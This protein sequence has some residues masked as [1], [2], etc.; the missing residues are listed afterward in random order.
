MLAVADYCPAQIGGMPL[1][2]ESCVNELSNEPMEAGDVVVH[3]DPYR[4]GLHT[5]EHTFFTPIFVGGE[6]MGYA[7]A[8]GHVSETG[9][10]VPG[11]F[12]SEATEIFHEG[13]RVPP[14]KIKRRGE[15]VDDVWKLMLANVRTPRQNYGDYRALISSVELGTQRIAD[16]IGKYGKKVFRQA[17]HELLDYSEKRMRAELA[18]IP[19]GRYRFSDFM[20]DDGIDDRPFHIR[21]ECVVQNDE[22]I[23]DFTGSDVQAR[24]AINAT[25]GV[26]RS[27]SYNAILHL[28]D[29]SIPKNSG[30]F[31]PIRIVAP[32]G[33]IVNVDYPAPEVGGNTETH[34]RIAYTVIGA[35]AKAVPDRA[36][37]T[38]AAT[39]CN[40]L[41]GGNDPRSGEY[42]VCYDFLSA[43]WGGRPF[44]DGNNAVNCINGNCRMIPTEVL[45]VRY[46]FLIEEF[47]LV[48]DSGGAGKY[49][50][51]LGVRKKFLCR[52]APITISHMGDRHKHGPWGLYGGGEAAKA[53]LKI[54]RAGSEKWQSAIQDSAKISPSKFAGM[55]LNPGDRIR[56]T[57]AGGGGW[58]K[59]G[60]RD[61]AQ[62]ANDVGEG[63]VS[64]QRAQ[65]DY[66][67]DPGNN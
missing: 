66:G 26:T 32:A 35:L 45:E 2:I 30:C 1:L 8:I 20:E 19:D 25:L 38:D 13:L 29:P 49:R 64:A 52:D 23:I 48:P 42:Y 12:A 67:Y 7:V 56:L 18:A 21:V 16:L 41:F 17:C 62:I 5:P 31:R 10:S 6:L 44:A 51:G 60:E 63:W 4:G 36:P 9:G 28:T 58:G 43:G 15:D 3:N 46:P 54:K 50:G 14:V 27:A 57:T 65:A 39:H 61:S 47:S 34:P 53:D 33:T 11:G 59:A 40:F 24:G 22:I 37:A 55:T